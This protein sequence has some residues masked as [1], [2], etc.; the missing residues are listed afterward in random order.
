MNLFEP[1][2]FYYV[3]TF[4]TSSVIMVLA[5][6]LAGMH[7]PSDERLSNF[8]TARFYLSLSYLVLGIS[9]FFS[10]FMQREAEDKM[11]LASSTLVIASYQA[12]LFTYTI[13]AL[14]QPLYVKRRM[15]VWQLA[16]ITI[17]SALLLTALS[18][19]PRSSFLIVFAMA[20]T[21]Y[22]FQITFY[23]H[24][25]RSQYKV[26]LN[27]LENY[28]E[29]DEKI[30]LRWARFGFYSALA[31]GVLALV[32]LFLD[33]YFYA[34]FSVIYTIYYAYMAT[35]LYNYQ[36]DFQFA[37]PVITQKEDEEKLQ[38]AVDDEESARLAAQSEQFR[39]VLARW[40]A[41]RKFTETDV[42]VE[43][44]AQS[45]GVSRSFLQYYFRTYMQ[46][47]FRIW[48]SALRIEEAQSILRDNPGIS[49]EKVRELVGFNHRANFHQQFQKITGLTPTEYRQQQSE[50]S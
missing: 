15:I 35:R 11:L 33:Y 30:R 25:F 43:E 17:A 19:L 47:D 27:S 22:F 1:V 29:E 21:G 37:I 10:F 32:S 2:P 4:A 31:V 8:R 48:R 14:I 46:T 23:T 13:L 18:L 16:I 40:V 7:I 49:L 39:R 45:L 42:S 20:V 26:C 24:T 34:L 44:I 12:L 9:G 5:A 28:Y 38:E 50:L 6:M 36:I 3:L 41:D